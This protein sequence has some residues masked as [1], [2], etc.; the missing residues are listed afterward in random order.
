MPQSST[1][2]CFGFVHNYESDRL[3]R[4]R[5]F[6]ETLGLLGFEFF[7]VTEQ[8]TFEVNFVNLNWLTY[9]RLILQIRWAFYLG[10]LTP[11]SVFLLFKTH[12]RRILSLLKS[13]YRLDHVAVESAIT[14]KHLALFKKFLLGS[15][16]E[17]LLVLESDFLIESESQ[18]FDA[19][20]DYLPDKSAD[21]SIYVQLS[22]GFTLEKIGCSHLVSRNTKERFVKTL[23]PFTNTSC[24]Y[25]VNRPL[26]FFVIQET[27]TSGLLHPI[28]WTLN[29]IFI[30]LRKLSVYM[31]S[32]ICL[33]PLVGHGTFQNTYKSW[34][35]ES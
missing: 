26:A 33:P 17:Y 4:I 31:L 16:K 24:A 34:Q 9:K 23:L 5:T 35:S 14:M 18:F 22:S 30:R 28:D 6:Q 12:V 7:E 1:S 27:S 21:N 20:Q 29:E 15:S 32:F 10:K 2:I 25:I 13:R 3:P 8:Q 11:W 19:L